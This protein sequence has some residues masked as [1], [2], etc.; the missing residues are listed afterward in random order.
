[1]SY[2]FLRPSDSVCAFRF[3]PLGPFASRVVAVGTSDSLQSQAA[4]YLN[5]IVGDY[6]KANPALHTLEPSIPA[7]IQSMAPLQH[8]N[9]AF[10]SGPPALSGSEPTRSLQFSPLTALAVAIRHRDSRH[11]QSLDGLLIL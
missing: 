3:L 10:A 4:T 1:M 11:P 6:P 2:S 9:A 7:A 5:N 8:A